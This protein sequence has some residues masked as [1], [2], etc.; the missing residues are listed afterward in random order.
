MP[1]DIFD[2]VAPDQA[3]DVFDHVADGKDIFDQLAPDSTT[4]A[5][6]AAVAYGK[7]MGLEL[8]P[9]QIQ[10]GSEQ[11]QAAGQAAVDV[12]KGIPGF[13]ASLP[14]Y[15]Y[16][17][18]KI[19]SGVTPPARA[20]EELLKEAAPMGAALAK[21]LQSPV[22][23]R[24]WYRG[25][26]QAGLMA[27]PGLELAREGIKPEITPV[28]KP[29]IQGGDIN[30]EQIS[31]TAP[32]H[33][34][35]QQPEVS[36]GGMPADQGGEGV[37]ARGQGDVVAGSA[38]E[39]QG[40]VA[41]DIAE[42]PP[43]SESG[44]A[45]AES[46]LPEQQTGKE[47]PS[48]TQAQEVQGQETG[49]LEAP[50][51]QDQ[52]VGFSQA[53]LEEQHPGQYEAGTYRDAE[54]WLEQGRKAINQGVDPRISIRRAERSGMTSPQDVGI[55]RAEYDRLAT[56]KRDAA[57]AVERDPGNLVAQ[58]Q[59]DAAEKAQSAW[60]QESMPVRTK[61]GEAFAAFQDKYKTDLSTYAGIHDLIDQTYEGKRILTPEERAVISGAVK[62]AREIS[63]NAVT[64]RNAV[65]DE[66]IRRTSPNRVM[67]FDELRNRV[68]DKL[69]EALKDCVT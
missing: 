55:I 25:M 51:V 53:S 68:G 42:A 66:V 34:D 2:Q 31:E 43:V 65:A 50:P 1:T 49:V 11:L 48:E 46:T 29:P 16:K 37:P 32:I 45:P 24:E 69:K 28:E 5:T 62:S 56:V 26:I 6:D 3:T 13:V 52:G 21:D 18:M 59:L 58:E 9:E 23:S 57:D 61:T 27:A 35:V 33:G 8:T 47:T 63:D 38:Q 19:A 54:H 12:A 36:G 20:A 15:A 67:A 22:G 44:Q 14:G 17:G 10:G 41:K 7:R 39:T 40:T 30:A 60:Q 64:A 4:P